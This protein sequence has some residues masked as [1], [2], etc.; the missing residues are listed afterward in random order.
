LVL[1]IFFFGLNFIRLL[2]NQMLSLDDI[3]FFVD[4]QMALQITRLRELLI[5]EMALVWLLTGVS[6]YMLFQG[7][8]ITEGLWTNVAGI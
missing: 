4:G 2:W 8:G 3:V 1:W 5:T 7:G 6:S